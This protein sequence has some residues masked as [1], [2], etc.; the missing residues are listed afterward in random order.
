[1]LYIRKVEGG[2]ERVSKQV[3][4]VLLA[5]TGES[6]FKTYRSNPAGFFVTRQQRAKHKSE[7]RHSPA[8]EKVG[9][10]VSK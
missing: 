2:K 3:L 10:K 4:S 5:Q 7:Q 1:M 8:S 9:E 6:F